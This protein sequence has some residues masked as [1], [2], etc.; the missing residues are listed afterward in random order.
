MTIPLLWPGIFSAAIF[1]F[2]ELGQFLH[3]LQPRRLDPNDP[4]LHL[5]RHR[6]GILTAYPAIATV[7]FVRAYCSYHRE[8]F[9]MRSV[10]A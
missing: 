5:Q 4:H 7:V 1:A 3:H 9:R 8:P 10:A 2:P 6:G